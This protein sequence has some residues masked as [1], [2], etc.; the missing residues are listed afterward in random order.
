MAVTDKIDL[1]STLSLPLISLLPKNL[2]KQVEEL[3]HERRIVMAD[4]VVSFGVEKLWDLLSRESERLQGV[5]EKV[6][7][8][9]CQMRMD[10]EG[11]T[12]RIVK[13]VGQMQSFGIQHSVNKPPPLQKRQREIQQTYPKRSQKDLVGVEQSVNELVGHLVENDSIQVVSISGM[14]GIGK[15]TLARQVFHHDIVRSHF[16]GFAWICVSQDFKRKDIWQ[17]LLRDLRP[18]DTGIEQMNEDTL[19]AKIFHLLETSKYL[20]VMDDVWK[21]EDWDA[22]KDA[23]PQ[24][25][26]WKMILTSRDEGVGLHVNPKSFLFKP[27]ILTPEESWKLCESIAFSRREITGF[28]VDE[29]LEAMGRKM[30]T[31]CGGLPLAVKVLGGLLANKYMV[32]DWKRINE[33]IQTQI[34]RLDDNNQDSVYRVLSMSYEDLPMQLKHCF[35]YLAH[36]PEDYKIQVERLYYLWEAEGIITSSGNGA[37]ARSI[38]EDYIDELVRRNMVIA[39]KEDLSCKLKYCQMHDMMREVC[40]NKAKEENFLQII[41]VPTSS[42]STINAQS[43]TGSRR[44]VVHGG[45]NALDMLGGKNNKKARSVLGF[46]LDSNL[47]KQSGQEFRNL[48]LL[49]VLDLSLDYKENFEFSLDLR[50]PS[51]IGKLI[52]LRYLS[53]AIGWATHVPSSLRNLKLLIYLKLKSYGSV[54]LPSI[55]N[56]MVELRFLMLPRYFDDKTKLELGNLV[57]LECLI[58]FRSECGSI[59]DFLRMTRLR[60]LHIKLKGRNYQKGSNIRTR[61]GRRHSYQVGKV[62]TKSNTFLVFNYTIIATTL[63]LTNKENTTVSGEP[64]RDQYPPLSI[65]SIAKRM[66]NWVRASSS[67]FAGTPP[68]PRSGHTAVNVGKSMVVVFGGLVDKKFLNDIIV[69]DIENKLWFEPECTGSVSEGKVGPTPRAFHVAITI[70]CHMFIFGGRSGGKRLGDFWVLDTDIWQWSELTSFGDLPT[71]RDFSAAA[72]IGNQKIVLCGGWDGKKWLS[73]VY[74]MDT[75]SL[76]WMELSV[77]GSLPPPRCGHTATMVEKRLLVFGGRGG[78]GPI[79][80]DLWA[81]KGLIDEER[82][83]PG[84]T[85][86]KLPGQAPSARCGHTVTSGGHYLLLFGGH[87]TGGWLS[88]YDVYYNDAIILDRVTAQWKRL[89][90]SNDEPPPPR[91]YH[92]MTSIGARLLLIGGFDGKST[93]G[94]LW[95]LVPED[96]PIAKRSSAPQL[97]NPPETKESEGE[98]NT[99]EGGQEGSTIVGLQK[100]MGISVPSIL[101]LQIPEESE[102]QE[103]VELGTRLI[104]G[105]DVVDNGASMIQMAAEA[106]RQHWKE[107]TPETLQLK[108]LSALLRDYQRLVTRKYTAQNSLTSADFG[109]PVKKTFTF[110]H[111]K[112]SSELRIDDTPKLLEE[113]KTLVI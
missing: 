65:T 112:R 85:Q 22:I 6:D 27:K 97:R 25:R 12:K 53:L 41:K 101:R 76:E 64:T 9:K 8:L 102:D 98:L 17:K 55:F 26:G 58:P 44:L 4:G 10:I 19:Q 31:Y 93:F 68:Q 21:K 78:G 71:P 110:Y 13:V 51:S 28:I 83:T 18:H 90:I 15:T 11:I 5:H 42:T 66:H 77:S 20:I 111:I 39:V 94:D 70:D 24:E 108:E 88:R 38:G 29:E 72:A 50:I 46:G 45:G 48:Q 54:H 14:G 30:V 62:T 84:W 109:L 36:F 33:N 37:T 47:W 23:F 2:S 80:G 32:E 105:D 96:D 75:M 40:L 52:H 57:N 67:D 82:E 43:H 81:L 89:P 49:R 63:I 74:V 61:S 103:F 113:Y 104:E 99:Q 34:V 106:L 91:A 60:T 87:G 35:L 69:Y 16:D 95:W 79:M 86:L 56:E 1:E 7:D 100:K 92:T 107:S 73:D 3:L 59:T